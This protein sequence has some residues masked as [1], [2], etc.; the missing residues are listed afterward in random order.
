MQKIE[1]LVSINK[2]LK[3]KCEN[4]LDYS[5]LDNL[6]QTLSNV[7]KSVSGFLVLKEDMT[8]TM[9]LCDFVTP[10]NNFVLKF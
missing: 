3:I 2:E 7:K 1:T 4:K 10:L 8:M 6:S 9:F 5:I